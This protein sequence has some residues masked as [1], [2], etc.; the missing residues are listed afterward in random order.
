METKKHN[1]VAAWILT[2][3]ALGATFI[4]ILLYSGA[5]DALSS[6]N[7]AEVLFGGILLLVGYFF[8]GVIS[9]GLS[10]YPIVRSCKL[11]FGE[12]DRRVPIWFIFALSIAV[13]VTFAT[14]TTLL[15]I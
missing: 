8:F 1:L 11:L 6:S 10:I 13:V 2:G 4:S 5:K 3:I 15:Y 7:A 9:V 14:L 12:K